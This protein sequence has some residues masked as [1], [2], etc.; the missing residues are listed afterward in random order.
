MCGRSDVRVSKIDG[1][2]SVEWSKEFK[3]KIQLE[4]IYFGIFFYFIKIFLF[5][6]NFFLLVNLKKILDYF[7]L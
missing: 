7:F 4:K 1:N 6:W 5:Y 3:K 2:D